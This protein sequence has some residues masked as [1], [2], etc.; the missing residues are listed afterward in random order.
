MVEH[1]DD[2][3]EEEA[4]CPFGYVNSDSGN[5][6]EKAQG[7]RMNPSSRSVGTT[8]HA[9]QQSSTATVNNQKKE[10]CPWP[11]IFSHDPFTGVQDWQTWITIGLVALVWSRTMAP[12]TAMTEKRCPWPFVFLH[13]P[14]TGIR[15]WQTYM[16]MGLMCWLVSYLKR[17]SLENKHWPWPF[18]FVQSF[19]TGL[20]AWQTWMV[21]GLV[22]CWAWSRIS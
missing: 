9:Q 11:F 18:V 21:I 16:L 8:N 5:G 17:L 6:N 14:V 20:K 13:D 1:G 19:G 4:K 22:L 3:Q 7:N 10:R 15:D 2:G 12:A